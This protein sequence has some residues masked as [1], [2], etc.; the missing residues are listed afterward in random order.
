MRE[1]VT[2]AVSPGEVLQVHSSRG[3][4]GQPVTVPQDVTSVTIIFRDSEGMKAADA[5]RAEKRGKAKQ[6]RAAARAGRAGRGKKK[7]EENED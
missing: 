1:K 5:R 4:I 2:T 6:G 7:Q 3:P